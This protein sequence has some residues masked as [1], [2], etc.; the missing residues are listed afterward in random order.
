MNEELSNF[1]SDL[2]KLLQEKSDQSLEE[3][4]KS[5]N[6]TDAAFQQGLN[7]AYYDALD[8]IR[9]QLEAFGYDAEAFGRFV[10]ELIAVASARKN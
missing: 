4:K 3:G 9:S 10:P 5:V 2:I 7:F 1:L 6:E 8:L